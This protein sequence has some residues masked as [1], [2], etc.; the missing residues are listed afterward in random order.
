MKVV[1]IMALTLPTPA[2][3]RGQSA[4]EM[5]VTVGLALAFIFPLVLLFQ[6][7]SATRGQQIT[8]LQAKGLA[9]QIADTAGQV[10]YQGNGSRKMLL[11][12]YPDTLQKLELSGDWVPADQPE[13]LKSDGREV[14]LTMDG[15]ASGRLQVA[16]SS[17]A[18]MKNAY[19]GQIRQSLSYGQSGLLRPGLVVLVFVNAGDYVN[20]SRSPGGTR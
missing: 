8:Q 10:W 6:S 17:P 1:M 11:V 18:P 12:S 4:T 3:R 5:L 16:A 7:T 9:Q 19:G 13:R 20:V 2:N 15:G 14:V